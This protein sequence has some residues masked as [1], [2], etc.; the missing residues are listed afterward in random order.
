M[1]LDAAYPDTAY[2][3]CP[4]DCPSACAPDIGRLGPDRIG[5]EHEGFGI[6]FPV[7][8]DPGPPMGGAVFRDSAVWIAAT[9]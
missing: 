8:A 4:H 6:A 9:E 3:V 5:A 2:S 1:S 7:S